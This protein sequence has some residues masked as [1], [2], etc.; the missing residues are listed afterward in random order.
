MIELERLTALLEA[1]SGL[2]IGLVGDLFLD[3]RFLSYNQR[4]DFLTQI[5]IGLD[6]TDVFVIP[7]RGEN[8]VRQRLE[9]LEEHSQARQ[10][11]ASRFTHFTTPFA[12]AP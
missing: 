12:S 9:N 3:R 5:Y 6:P 4:D 2:T 11:T 1:Y 8:I 10:K 7:A